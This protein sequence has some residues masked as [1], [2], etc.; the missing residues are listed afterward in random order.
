MA[1]PIANL[2][3]DFNDGTIN[4]SKW[5]VTSGTW[6]ETGG[7]LCVT[8]PSGGSAFNSTAAW[9]LAQSMAFIEIV[10]FA[11]GAGAAS[12]AEIYRLFNSA[13]SNDYVQFILDPPSNTLTFHYVENAVIQASSSITY[14]ATTMRWLRFRHFQD[15]VYFE[16]SPDGAVWTERFSSVEPAW[17]GSVKVLL[18]ASQSGGAATTK[19]FDNFNVSPASARS[20]PVGTEFDVSEDGELGLN[21]CD[22]V[23]AAWGFSCPVSAYNALRRS[24]NPC[25]HWVQPPAKQYLDVEVVVRSTSDQDEQ[26][27]I[28]LELTNPDT[29]RPMLFYL[30]LIAGMKIVQP[31]T[32][33]AGIFS[34]TLGVQVSGVDNPDSGFQPLTAN[35]FGNLPQAHFWRGTADY[36][37][38]ADPGATTTIEVILKVFAGGGEADLTQLQARLGIIGM[39]E[40]LA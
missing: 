23:D 12:G 18:F 36:Y 15:R 8:M 1:A 6:A 31:T 29:C 9:S 11:N 2:W 10:S 30:P 24:E 37:W 17:V 34:W 21:R 27:I 13:D 4:T 14:N 32:D 20:V 5:T 19:C 26:T 35:D 25:G 16:T 3:D 22:Q 28:T 39:S 7:A 33:D 38:T 40:V